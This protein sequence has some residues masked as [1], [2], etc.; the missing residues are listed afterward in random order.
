MDKPFLLF[1][2]KK[3]NNNNNRKKIIKNFEFLSI[4]FATSNGVNYLYN[5][6][7]ICVKYSLFLPTNGTLEL[8]QDLAAIKS[9]YSFAKAV[10]KEGN[11]S[12]PYCRTITTE[13]NSKGSLFL[14]AKEKSKS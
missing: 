9:Q 1:L 3:K 14:L 8:V 4:Q 5:W 6:W 2:L 11:E 13:Y 12:Q 10:R 7:F